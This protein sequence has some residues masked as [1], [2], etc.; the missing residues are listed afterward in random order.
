MWTRPALSSSS[1]RSPWG[2]RRLT[3]YPTDFEAASDLVPLLALFLS[4]RF[5][6]FGNLLLAHGDSRAVFVV[7]LIGATATLA[8][9]LVG[10]RLG[11]LEGAIAGLTL[12]RLVPIPF[13]LGRA[14]PILGRRQIIGGAVWLVACAARGSRRGR[15]GL[16][17]TGTLTCIRSAGLSARPRVEVVSENAGRLGELAQDQ[18]GGLA[19]VMPLRRQPQDLGAG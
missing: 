4:F 15:S 2:L 6:M 5:R 9:L 13:L 12:A 18:E 14:A 7:S 1:V 11:G 8:G 16:G 19:R 10:Q 17:V 3:F